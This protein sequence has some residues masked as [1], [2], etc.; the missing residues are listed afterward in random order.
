MAN[1]TKEQVINEEYIAVDP[2]RLL[3]FLPMLPYQTIAD[4]GSGSGY[5]TIPFAK[6]VFS[7]KVYAIDTE[8]KALDETMQQVRHINLTNV[9]T[10]R[11]K[12]NK[13]PLDDEC[14]DG[15]IAAFTL[16]GNKNA[17]S[18]LEDTYRSMRKGAWL[19]LIE[20]NK[21]S[22][23]VGPP[24]KDR[25][26]ESDLLKVAEQVGFRFTTRQDINDHKY[27]ILMRK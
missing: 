23:S 24:M 19:A 10:K 9:E 22:R 8:K 6:Y 11:L 15:S 27:M 21:S 5:F 4:I 17:K 16:G 26:Q 25:I 2:Q 1:K 14:L 20:W 18:L 7:G 12:A 13:L 3:A